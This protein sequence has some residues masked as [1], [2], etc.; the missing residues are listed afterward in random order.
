MG[1]DWHWRLSRT[2]DVDGRLDV[3]DDNDADDDA[4]GDADDANSDDDA[5]DDANSDEDDAD[6]NDDG[7]DDRNNNNDLDDHDDGDNDYDDENALVTIIR[8]SDS[9]LKM[10]GTL[11]SSDLSGLLE[12]LVLKRKQR[13]DTCHDLRLQFNKSNN[14]NFVG[15][16]YQ[17]SKPV[18]YYNSLKVEQKMFISS[19]GQWAKISTL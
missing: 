3:D 17:P 12:L 14:C 1:H 8:L 4:D 9:C 16:I 19:I 13:V 18:W 2:N 10:S 7:N 11:V 6:D 15:S 5:A